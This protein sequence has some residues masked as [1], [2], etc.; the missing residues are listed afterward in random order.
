[1][2][3]HCAVLC[4]AIM[5]PTTPSSHRYHATLLVEIQ[6]NKTCLNVYAPDLFPD[7][8]QFQTEIYIGKTQQLL[9]TASPAQLKTGKAENKQQRILLFFFLFENVHCLKGA[10]Q[11]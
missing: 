8:P 11:F 7:Y 3:Y 4:L 9:F 2:D 5:Y 6:M 10:C 1:M